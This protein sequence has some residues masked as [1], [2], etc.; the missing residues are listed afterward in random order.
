[1]TLKNQIM[2]LQ[3]YKMYE[4]EDTVYIERDDVLKVLEQQTCDDCISRQ[5]IIRLVEQ[6][7][8]IIGNRCVGLMADIKHLPSVTPSYNSVKTELYHVIDEIIIRIEQTRDK[9][10]LCEYP[11]NRCIDIVK[12]VL[13]DD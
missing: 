11:Y 7:P 13:G 10:K 12:E 5:A 8:N 1:M 3:T 9:D 4:G 2:K 6:Y